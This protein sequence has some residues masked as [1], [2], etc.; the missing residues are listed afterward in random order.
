MTIS[1]GT[2]QHTGP[3]P[4]D[5]RL[6]RLLKRWFLR[7]G[8]V[9]SVASFSPN[10]RL[11]NL[12][13]EQLKDVSWSPGQQIQIGVGPGM[14]NR[15]YTPL[16]WSA[17]KGTTQI[18][19][20]L[21]G[22]GPATRLFGDLQPEQDFDFLGP[23]GSVD[24]SDL[25]APT[26]LFGDETCFGL[27]KVLH[28]QL[29]AGAHLLFEV[30][31]PIESRSVLQAIGL[32]DAAHVERAPDDSHLV[33]V[34]EHLSRQAVDYSHFI[35]AGKASSIQRARQILKAAGVAPSRVRAKAYW[36][37]GKTGLD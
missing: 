32:G 31:E 12:A 2:A 15:T 17:A 23:R 19:V 3:Q 7:S 25:A 35:L 24:L 8:Q 29:G 28:S 20:Y 36:A 26:L 9:A 4:Q 18:L 16:S 34:E 5:G 33:D 11:V 1:N 13:G 14:I 27:A 30:T 37:P 6:T 21:H 10:F 22:E